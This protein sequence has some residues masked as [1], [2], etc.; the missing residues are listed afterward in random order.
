MSRMAPLQQLQVF[1][2]S[3]GGGHA[4][5]YNCSHV[6]GVCRQSRVQTRFRY[7]RSSQREQRCLVLLF[8]LGVIVQLQAVWPCDAAFAMA[9]P[10][11]RNTYA[12]VGHP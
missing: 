9:M 4:D 7:Q 6:F 3:V 11:H 5:I 10:T 8:C 12:H 2:M 1:S